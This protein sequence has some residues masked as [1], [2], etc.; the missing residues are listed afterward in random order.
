M[1]GNCWFPVTGGLFL[2]DDVTNA[3]TQLTGHIPVTQ[4]QRNTVRARFRYQLMPR[5]WLAGGL[6][7]G[8]G[9]P[10]DFTGTYEEALAEYGLQVVSRI[11]F[12]RGR[13]DPLLAFNASLGMNVYKTEKLNVRFQADG[14]N[15][16]NRLNII[17]FG[18]LFSGNAI[19]P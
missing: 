17:V 16:N 6:D 7:S 1:V 15:L 14:E 18:G 2:G 13:I 8:S 11:N 5:F 9:L 12:R 10:V 19:A 4:D 3:L